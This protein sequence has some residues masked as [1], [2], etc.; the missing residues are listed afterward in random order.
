MNLG[1]ILKTVGSGLIKTLVPGGGLLIDAV[2]G[3]LPDDK[4]LPN[5]ATGE[6]AQS[7]IDSLPPEQRASVLKKEYDVKIEQIKPGCMADQITGC[8]VGHRFFF[9]ISPKRLHNRLDLLKITGQ[10]KKIRVKSGQITC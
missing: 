4:K 3:F 1:D 10:P 7:A 5:D 9:S 8:R 2:N 6:Q